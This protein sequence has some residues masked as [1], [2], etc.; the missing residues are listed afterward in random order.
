MDAREAKRVESE[1]W[2]K[3][4]FAEIERISAKSGHIIGA[5]IVKR[6]IQ[7]FDIVDKNIINVG[8]GDGEEAEFL[9]KNRAGAVTIVDIAEGPLKNACVRRQK[10]HLDNLECVRG[11]AGYLPFKDVS[12]DLG[13]FAWHCTISQIMPE[14]SLRYA[15]FREK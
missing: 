4:S 5:P 12:F 3:S 11:D 9:L 6:S 7:D 13:T 10:H 15:G 14:A 2:G 1:A 8:G